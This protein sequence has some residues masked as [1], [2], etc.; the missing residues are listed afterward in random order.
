LIKKSPNK[1]DSKLLIIGTSGAGRILGELEISK[2]FD[3][4]M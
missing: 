4:K 2:S 1:R 3:I